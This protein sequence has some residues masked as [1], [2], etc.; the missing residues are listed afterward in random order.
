MRRIAP[1]LLTAFLF[2]APSIQTPRVIAATPAAP[3]CKDLVALRHAPVPPGKMIEKTDTEL[4]RISEQRTCFKSYPW[5]PKLIVAEDKLGTVTPS[6]MRSIKDEVDALASEYEQVG[7]RGINR[8]AEI[9]LVATNFYLRS[10]IE[11]RDLKLL[12]KF[13]YTLYIQV[14][15]RNRLF[16]SAKVAVDEAFAK[17]PVS[18]TDTAWDTGDKN[19][20][21]S[22]ETLDKILFLLKYFMYS[23]IPVS[24]RDQALVLAGEF[25][26]A[27]PLL[28][29]ELNLFD[30]DPS[31]DL[32]ANAGCQ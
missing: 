16:D 24:S 12:R 29:N 2:V 8:H 26:R 14:L 32:L 7:A 1:T 20:Y 28:A 9:D 13:G 4:I 25:L 11:K 5:P 6:E 21:F 18:V 23:Q 15:A 22:D 17:W 19:T 31:D 30:L 27:R 3:T 10:H